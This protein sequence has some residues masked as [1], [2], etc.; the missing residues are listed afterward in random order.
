MQGF[1]PEDLAGF[2]K[3]FGGW[4]LFP[5]SKILAILALL[6]PSFLGSEN[7]TLIL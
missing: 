4:P 1:L 5:Y 3:G 2:K 6:S 7:P